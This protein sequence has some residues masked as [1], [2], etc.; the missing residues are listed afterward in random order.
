MSEVTPNEFAGVLT[1]EQFDDRVDI[2]TDITNREVL[3]IIGRSLK[4]LADVRNLFA[5]KFMLAML[6]LIPG[7]IAPWIGKIVIDQVILGKQIDEA[8][9]RFP[10]HVSPFIDYI[11]GLEPLETMLAIVVLMGIILVLFGRGGSGVLLSA[12]RDSATQSEA[13]LNAGGSQ[14]GGIFGAIEALIHIRLNQRLVNGLRTRLFSG[15]AKLPMITLDD[16]RIGDSVYRVMYDAPDVPLICFELTLQ[17]FFTLVGVGISLYLLQYSYG[18]VA[19]E[20]IWISALLV[21]LSLAVTLPVSSLMRRVQQASRAAGTVTTNAIEES[22][23]NIHAVQSLGGMS[24]EKERIEGKSRESFRR[25]RHVRIIEMGLT[26]LS[27][28]LMIAL[29]VFVTVYVTD[30]IFDG[31]MTPGDFSVLFGMAFSIGGSGLQIGML[32]INLQG[33]VAAVRRVFFFVDLDTEDDRKEL[34]DLTEVRE[35]VRFDHVGFSYPNGH[36]ALSDIN[37][38]FA[39]G[40]IIAIVGPTG[41]GKTSLAHL[42]PGFYR[43]TEG[44]VLIDGH[45][46][47]AVNVASL[48]SQVSYVFQEHLLMSE[49]I[50]SNFSLVNPAASEADMMA[51]CRMAE[52]EKFIDSLPDGLD[53]VLG[54]SGDTLSVGQKQRLCI[55]RGLVRNTRI[56]ILDEPTAALD[57]RKENALVLALRRAAAGRLVVVIA[58]RLS[59]IR[60][61][62]RIVFLEDG[63]VRDVGSHDALVADPKGRYRRFVELQGGLASAKQ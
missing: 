56:L 18:A 3:T 38:E 1:P 48:R 59:T 33:N 40:E 60:K 22:M 55:A 32:W 43:P 45:D 51:A 4:L 11:R 14:T 63:K 7:L 37:I 19:P 42:I 36:Q 30:Q 58:H 44:R 54:R 24:R 46:I 28:A 2:H 17:P 52:A 13:K 21:P 41:A 62:D 23:S 26:V 53:T 61:A 10:P 5:A 15:L 25:F 49:S 6:A 50:R 29:G 9:V 27:T 47:A 16:H 8:T 35:G 20:L 31:A 12:G 39:I 34:D 57:P